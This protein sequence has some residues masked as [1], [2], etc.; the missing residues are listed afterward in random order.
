[1]PKQQEVS[2]DGQGDDRDWIVRCIAP[3]AKYWKQDES[4]H[5]FHWDTSK[6]WGT[7]KTLEF[8]Q[9]GDSGGAS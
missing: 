3:N 4:F 2:G 6:F 9:H 5:L 8:T 1:M 7:A